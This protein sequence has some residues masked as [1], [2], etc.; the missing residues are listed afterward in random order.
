MSLLPPA[1]TSKTIAGSL[2][3]N[4]PSCGSRPAPPDRAGAAVLQQRC[5][6]SA[7]QR[8]GHLGNLRAS[9]LKARRGSQCGDRTLRPPRLRFTRFKSLSPY[10]LVIPALCLNPDMLHSLQDWNN[11]TV[12][13]GLEHGCLGEN[14]SLMHRNSTQRSHSGLR[15]M[16]PK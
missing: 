9:G 7:A 14:W 15:S 2:Q 4:T 6:P 3:G 1:S 16:K 13:F 10:T 11:L 8:N 5:R 12:V